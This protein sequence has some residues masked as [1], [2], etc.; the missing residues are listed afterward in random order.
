MA[1]TAYQ[2]ATYIVVTDQPVDEGYIASW[3]VDDA[4][5]D[6]VIIENVPFEVVE[7]NFIVDGEVI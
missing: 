3:Q 1:Y 4:I 2:Y 7:N 5:A 6:K